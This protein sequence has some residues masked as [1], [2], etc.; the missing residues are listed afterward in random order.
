M[1][2]AATRGSSRNTKANCP[3]AVLLSVSA[4]VKVT[5]TVPMAGT[6]PVTAATPWNPASNPSP[7]SPSEYRNEA[8]SR[9]SDAGGV[10]ASRNVALGILY[11][12]SPPAGRHTADTGAAYSGASDVQ[13][14]LRSTSTV[15]VTLNSRDA[16]SPVAGSW[17]VKMT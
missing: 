4:A 2:L 8:L 15:E 6:L 17:A 12:A 10:T 13:R 1:G 16:V 3:C 14:S 11:G 9:L 5:T 7:A